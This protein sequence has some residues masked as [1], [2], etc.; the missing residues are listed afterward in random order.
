MSI[1]SVILSWHR[2][3]PS[4]PLSSLVVDRVLTFF[5]IKIVEK[6]VKDQTRATQDLCLC[7][8]RA[9]GSRGHREPQWLQPLT[10][11]WPQVK[12]MCGGACS[13]R[14]ATLPPKEL[15]QKSSTNLLTPM[16]PPFMTGSTAGI[17][18]PSISEK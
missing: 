16:L 7:P 10:H 13:T 6:E 1:A 18:D 3:E 14:G 5:Y 4:E 15:V 9:W 17:L 12:A 11:H 8:G 2:L